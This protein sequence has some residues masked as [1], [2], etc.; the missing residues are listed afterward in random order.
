MPFGSS[1]LPQPPTNATSYSPFECRADFELANLLFS[2]TQMPA[3]QI[4]AL[5]D[6]WASKHDGNTPFANH[7]D[8]YSRIDSIKL[9]D[10][11]WNCFTVSYTG[12][13]P[14]A[15]N[16]DAEVPPWMDA[17]YEVWYRDP[18]AVLEQQI[19]NPE[20]KDHIHYAPFQEFGADGERRWQDLMSAN[21][22]WSQAVR[23]I[24]VQW[25]SMSDRESCSRMSSLKIQ[26]RTGQRLRPSYLEV[27]KQLCL[28]PLGRTNTTPCMRL[29]GTSIT[30]HAVRTR[31]LSVFWHSYLSLKVRSQASISFTD[32]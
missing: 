3:K 24:N 22:A 14:N 15:D 4:D 10:A 1:P 27:T 21:W 6:I 18:K 19:G 11:P 7:K 5:L 12:Q 13:K 30:L 20:L 25:L 2:R 17:E 28:W 29:W 32:C 31:M 9:G 8:M 16:P 26:T 23:K